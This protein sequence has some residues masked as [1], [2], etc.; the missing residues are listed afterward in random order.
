MMYRLF[1]CD[2]DASHGEGGA[3]GFVLNKAEEPQ[4]CPDPKCNGGEL[5][6]NREC[7]AMVGGGPAAVDPPE[8]CG[9]DITPGKIYCE[10]HKGE[11][12]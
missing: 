3:A 11:D 6:L 4:R 8:A 9:A 2:M 10:R 1:Y 5:W 7:V 12:E